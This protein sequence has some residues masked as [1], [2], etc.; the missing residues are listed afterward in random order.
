VPFSLP[1]IDDALTG[2]HV[3]HRGFRVSYQSSDPA[4]TTGLAYARAVI[5]AAVL[6]AVLS[7]I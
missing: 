3:C 7:E 2:K 6:P 4:H 5:L 1:A